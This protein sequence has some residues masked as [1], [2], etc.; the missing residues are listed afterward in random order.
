L[1]IE[2]DIESDTAA[3]SELVERLLDATSE[4]RCM[5]DATRGGVA[6]VLNE[7]AS[8]SGVGIAIDESRVPLKEGSRARSMLA[9]LKSRR[10]PVIGC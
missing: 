4:V 2:A 5:R 9:S 7:I 8:A 1:E 3:L 6:T 10:G